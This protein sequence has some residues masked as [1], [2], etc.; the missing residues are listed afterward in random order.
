[1]LIAEVIFF[2]FDN[3]KLKLKDFS[4]VKRLEFTAER[5]FF[6]YLKGFV[7]LLYTIMIYMGAKRLF[8][9]IKANFVPIV[10][11]CGGA[12]K[13]VFE[14]VITLGFVA[15]IFAGVCAIVVVYVWL[16]SLK[17]KVKK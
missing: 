17:Y 8:L 10:S 2:F 12:L 16:N 1:V 14:A 4:F 15:L 6:A 9:L 3:E 5:K 11:W 7:V 13:W